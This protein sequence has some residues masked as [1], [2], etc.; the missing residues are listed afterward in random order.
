MRYLALLL[1]VSCASSPPPQ[2]HW[3]KAGGSQEMLDREMAECQMTALQS[4]PGMSVERGGMIFVTCM[5]SKG[6]SII[7]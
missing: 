6:W 4:H 1:L 5:R 7:R 2:R 3:T